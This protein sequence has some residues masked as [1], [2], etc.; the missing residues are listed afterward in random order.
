MKFSGGM[1]VLSA[2]YITAS[3]EKRRNDKGMEVLNGI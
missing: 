2:I 1:F 3:G